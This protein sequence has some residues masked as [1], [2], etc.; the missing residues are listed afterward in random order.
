MTLPQA[1][2]AYRRLTGGLWIIMTTSAIFC[3]SSISFM[4]Y[5][6]NG[7]ERRFLMVAVLDDAITPTEQD[8]KLARKSSRRLSGFGRQETLK[9]QIRGGGH[10][11]ETVELPR[12]AVGLLVR[13]LAEM[14]E[15][16]AI[17]IMPT[18]AELTTQRAAE[19]LGVS[20][21]FLIQQ[22]EAG[23]IPFRKVGTHRRIQLRDLMD[24]Q[25]RIDAKREKALDELAAQAQELKMGY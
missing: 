5:D 21:P 25:R 7:C 10:T 6:D 8:V 14:A 16:N 3:V 12:A 4:H 20:R 19:M 24:Y 2:S 11:T 22:L 15:G 23:K 13:I 18:Q 9:V 17:T 1:K